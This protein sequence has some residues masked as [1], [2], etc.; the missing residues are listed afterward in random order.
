MALRP[1]K[2]CNYPRCPSLTR[3]THCEKHLIDKYNDQVDD[4]RFYDRYSR[5][6]RSTKFYKSKEWKKI[7][8]YVFGLSHG[9]CD[10]CRIRGIITVGNVVHHIIEIKK[11]WSKRLDIDNLICLCNSCHNKIDHYKM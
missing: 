8:A 5:D 6:E 2:P 9:L 7:R 1:L 4:L 11:D 10:Q 3:D